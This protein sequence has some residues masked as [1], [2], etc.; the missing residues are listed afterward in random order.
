[1]FFIPFIRLSIS[2][3]PT[4]NFEKVVYDY[5]ILLLNE[6]MKES[7]AFVAEEDRERFV[8]IYTNTFQQSAKSIYTAKR[9]SKTLA[10]SLPVLK[11]KVNICDLIIITGIKIFYPKLYKLIETEGPI[12]VGPIPPSAEYTSRK[13][14]IHEL[15]IKLDTVINWYDEQSDNGGYIRGMLILLFPHLNIVY[16]DIQQTNEQYLECLEKKRIC[17]DEHFKLYFSVKYETR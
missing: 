14:H 15:A 1:M 2:S 10:E 8:S 6:V 7:D 13:Q 17:S 16:R 3:A 9:H 12:L 11:D 4:E 5:A